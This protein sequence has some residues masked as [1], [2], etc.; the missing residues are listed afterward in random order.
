M[1]N[2]TVHQL[3][4]R[5]LKRARTHTKYLY[6]MTHSWYVAQVCYLVYNVIRI[7]EVITAARHSRYTR[8]R[9]L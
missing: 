3:L 2:K 6:R 7:D 8:I 1:K 9:E 4:I 5:F